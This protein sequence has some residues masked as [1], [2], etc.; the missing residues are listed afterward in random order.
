MKKKIVYKGVLKDMEGPSIKSI[1]VAGQIID[2]FQ[3]MKLRHTFLN[4]AQNGEMIY[5]FPLPSKATVTGFTAK[6]G[7]DKVIGKI[8]ESTEGENSYHNALEDGNSGILLKSNSEGVFALSLGQLAKGDEVEINLTYM[9]EQQATK[10]Q[11][12]IIIPTVLAPKYT[13]M[14]PEGKRQKPVDMVFT[15]AVYPVNIQMEI[16]QTKSIKEITSPS[17]DIATEYN[18]GNTATYNSGNTVT[19]N[20]GNSATV[21]F[22]AEKDKLDRDFVLNISLL[23]NMED[24]I[25]IEKSTGKDPWN[26]GRLVFTPELPEAPKTEKDYVFLIDVSGSMDGIKMEEA[27][28]ALQLCLR[29]LSEGDRFSMAAFESE[30]HYFQKDLLEYDA[31]NLSIASAWV[32][33]LTTLGGTEMMAAVKFALKKKTD[34]E[35]V[36]VLITDGQ[37]SNEAELIRYVSERNENLKFYGI[38]IDTSVNEGFMQKISEAGNGFCELI[39]P[40]ENIDEKVIRHFARINSSWLENIEI[41]TKQNKK[42]EKLELADGLTERIFDMEPVG[43]LFRSKEIPSE[44]LVISGKAKDGNAIS[45]EIGKYIII[46]E[47]INKADSLD[48]D[49]SIL[50]KLWGKDRLRKLDG[51]IKDF[52]SVRH[53]NHLINKAVEVSVEFGILSKYTSFFAEYV[54]EDKLNGKLKTYLVPVAQPRDWDMFDSDQFNTDGIFYYSGVSYCCTPPSLGMNSIS[55]AYMK[56]GSEHEEKPVSKPNTILDFAILQEA[57]GSFGI[58]DDDLKNRILKT[59][60]FIKL[61]IDADTEVNSLRKQLEKALEF[62]FVNI[63]TI[64]DMGLSTEYQGMLDALVKAKKLKKEFLERWNQK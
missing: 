33:R 46:D 10:G 36:V 16:L 64:K 15:S 3:V 11:Y 43:I 20:S 27:K 2:G 63:E 19:Y 59:M 18:S 17:H 60:D 5:N 29:N 53:E 45:F 31:R 52:H 56:A 22:S 4:N 35:T 24:S 44:P 54:R 58:D 7:K 48:D 50:K 26:Y 55:R 1:S 61:V 21:R 57:D 39:Y 32:N 9:Q 49:G 28:K 41:N 51:E 13:P 38:G 8:M 6:I 25:L 47:L 30:L 14:D 23:G 42:G 62:L 12:H 40:G 37:V 34:R